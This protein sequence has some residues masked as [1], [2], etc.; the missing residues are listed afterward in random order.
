[1]ANRDLYVQSFS[2]RTLTQC[3]RFRCERIPGKHSAQEFCC[4]AG[5]HG[6]QVSCGSEAATTAHHSL[7]VVVK[8]KC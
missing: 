1:M 4:V 5:L 8:W 7:V 3:E 2:R 6:R